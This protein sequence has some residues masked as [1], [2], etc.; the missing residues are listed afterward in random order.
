MDLKYFSIISWRYH[1][2]LPT[3]L[4]KLYSQVH[5]D[6]IF[7]NQTNIKFFLGKKK[8]KC[9]DLLGKVA[10]TLLIPKTGGQ[11]SWEISSE[12]RTCCLN[13]KF[14]ASPGYTEQDLVSKTNKKHNQKKG[15]GNHS[16]Y[17]VLGRN[18]EP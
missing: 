3:N 5:N 8:K 6:R 10:C 15:I 13:S 18:Y 9:K 11:R 17:Q 2:L 4:A 1:R 12:L 7:S 16:V 14:Q